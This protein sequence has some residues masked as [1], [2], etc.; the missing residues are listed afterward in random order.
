LALPA[1]SRACLNSGGYYGYSARHVKLMNRKVHVRFEGSV[2]ICKLG[3]Y[4]GRIFGD[5]VHGTGRNCFMATIIDFKIRCLA[6]DLDVDHCIFRPI[7]VFKVDC[8]FKSSMPVNV[9][10]S[11]LAAY[12]KSFKTPRLNCE[13]LSKTNCGS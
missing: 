1:I 7:V 12:I 13:C 9:T 8:K 5:H 4:H 3:H 6:N 2:P 11:G 10:K